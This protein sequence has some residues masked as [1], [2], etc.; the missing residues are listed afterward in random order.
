MIGCNT[1]PTPN[2]SFSLLPLYLASEEDRKWCV[3]IPLGLET[4]VHT[5]YQ[6]EKVGQTKNKDIAVFSK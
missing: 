4:G 6:D 1:L 3:Y 5:G 2:P